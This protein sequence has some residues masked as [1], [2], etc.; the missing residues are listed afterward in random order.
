MSGEYKAYTKQR[1]K[2]MNAQRRKRTGGPFMHLIVTLAGTAFV[3][4][5]ICSFVLTQADIAEKKQELAAL[6]EKAAELEI[7]NDEYS[8]ILAE[9]D[10][11]AYME[12][13]AVDVLGY[14]YPN[15]RHF[16]DTT[17]N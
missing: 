13:I 11:R 3:V 8:S 5:C 7:E 6:N 4:Y 1:Q 14:A 17:R 10:E 2:E 16:Y 15:E 12:R 9:D